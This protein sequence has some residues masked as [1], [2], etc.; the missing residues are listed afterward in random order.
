MYDFMHVER[1]STCDYLDLADRRRKP[2]EL[3]RPMVDYCSSL[4]WCVEVAG[5]IFAASLLDNEALQV[6]LLFLARHNNHLLSRVVL[7]HEL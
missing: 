7:Q 2:P 6:P 1:T 3:G 5:D 4:V